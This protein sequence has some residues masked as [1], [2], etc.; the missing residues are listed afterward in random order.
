MTDFFFPAKEEE[1]EDLNDREVDEE[2]DE[3]KTATFLYGVVLILYIHFRFDILALNISLI[4][5]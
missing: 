4:P 5:I 1:E 3:G 2:D